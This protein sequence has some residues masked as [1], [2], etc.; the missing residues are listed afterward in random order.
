MRETR[1]AVASLLGTHKTRCFPLCTVVSDALLERPA[2]RS[3]PLLVESA[4]TCSLTVRTT[5]KS[6]IVRCTDPPISTPRP[7]AHPPKALGTFQRPA[8]RTSADGVRGSK[9][10]TCSG[11]VDRGIS[12]SW[13]AEDWGCTVGDRYPSGTCCGVLSL[14]E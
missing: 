1:K 5:K 9:W 6:V 3:E 8:P 11:W 4:L 7:Y 13:K 2:L 10:R 14:G 12:Q